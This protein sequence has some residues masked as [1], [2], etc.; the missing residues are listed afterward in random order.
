MA[1]VPKYVVSAEGF[2]K[3]PAGALATNFP[4]TILN[5]P[6]AGQIQNS[7]GAFGGNALSFAIATSNSAPSM[8]YSYLS[9]MNPVRATGNDCVITWS[10]YVNVGVPQV[11]GTQQILS[12]GNASTGY[13]LMAILNSTATG[14]NLA[15]P[16]TINN[17]NSSPFLFA[18]SPNTY[19]WVTITIAFNGSTSA[20]NATYT[21]NGNVIQSNVS[22]GWTASVLNN[23]I[24]TIGL[25][26]GS[27]A[28]WMLDD[29]VIQG[30]SST[31]ANWPGGA[32]T[33]SI[34]PQLPPREITDAVAIADGP[35]IQMTPSGAEPN[36]Q[37]A[38]D[39][40]GA[41]FVTATATGQ[42]DLYEWTDTGATDIT[43]I[44][45]RGSSNRWSNLVPQVSVGGTQ[46]SFPAV[47]SGASRFI[48]VSE[49][50]GTDDWTAA[51]IAA[52][53]FGQES[54]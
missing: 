53:F 54:H 46:S 17:I 38:T 33:V 15:F 4:W 1:T 11:V 31:D 12:M 13:A 20:A 47:N 9:T 24:D 48:G 34:T 10:G 2:N 40:T 6:T 39:A 32:A 44:V 5:A 14:L 8:T 26:S 27:V 25:W 43:C 42:T 16:S 3:Y 45:Y 50:D 49:N 37:S 18:I 22:L 52:A 35:I 29:M 36:W 41:N 21:I 30:V 51:S 28:A 23:I 7:T 19:Y